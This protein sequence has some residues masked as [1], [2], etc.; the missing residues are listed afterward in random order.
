MASSSLIQVDSNHGVAAQPEDRYLKG[1]VFDK[2]GVEDLRD[3]I[4]HPME[5]ANP[6]VRMMDEISMSRSDNMCLKFSDVYELEKILGAG[7][8]GLAA[9]VRKKSS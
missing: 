3:L 7:S 6:S 4:L 5:W 9:A 8:F 2:L 1:K